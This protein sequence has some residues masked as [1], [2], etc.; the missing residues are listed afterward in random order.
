[1]RS[2]E[3]RTKCKMFDIDGDGFIP[4]DSLQDFFPA[5]DSVHILMKYVDDDRDGLITQEQCLS[6][7][8]TVGYRLPDL[9]VDKTQTCDIYVNVPLKE[10]GYAYA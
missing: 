7:M 2:H 9:K 1:M 6:V 10:R 3:Q 5:D 8:Q 4:L